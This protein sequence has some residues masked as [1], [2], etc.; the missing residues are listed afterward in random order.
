MISSYKGGVLV[1]ISIGELFDRVSVLNVKRE[2]IKDQSKLVHVNNEYKLL[3]PLCD[4]FT[5]E[6]PEINQLLSDITEVN[7][8]LWD[9]LELQRNKEK[10][11]ELDQEFINIS[12]SVYKEN[13]KRFFIKNKINELTSSEIQEQK[14]YTAGQ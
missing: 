2:K 1:P 9:I 7:S 13:D 14:H 12:I 11:K 10:N 3:K 8:K 5:T 6:R 4:E